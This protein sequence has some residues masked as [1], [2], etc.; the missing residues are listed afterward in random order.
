MTSPDHHLPSACLDANALAAVAEG[1]LPPDERRRAAEHLLG[2]PRCHAALGEVAVWL[3]TVDAAPGPTTVHGVVRTRFPRR[4]LAVAALLAAGVGVALWLGGRASERP[5]R[6]ETLA[7]AAVRLGAPLLP[8][9][10]LA[11]RP[12]VVE[13]G[14]LTVAAPRGLVLEERPEVRYTPVPG[15]VRVRVSVRDEEGV[16][17]L[18][19][20]PA[21]VGAGRLAWPET[22]AGLPPGLR[23]VVRVVAETPH[24]VV[25]GSAAFGTASTHD[26][27]E[28]LATRARLA[29]SAPAGLA[30]LLSAHVAAHL[31]LWSEAD[32]RL[33]AARAAGAE[34]GDVDRLRAR[35][36]HQLGLD[37]R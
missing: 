17:R 34:A 37:A 16:L 33:R 20:E 2:C 19:A 18:D 21:A 29:A 8:D 14:G 9:A 31:S 3:G 26:R 22:S 30:E 32:A 35:V 7:E 5:A 13:R 10:V 11:E 12:L 15:A 28:Y 24:G 1:R 36:D 4:I 6:T 25:E 23:A 27:Q